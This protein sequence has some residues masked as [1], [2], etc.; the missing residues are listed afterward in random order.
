M[1]RRHPPRVQPPPPEPVVARAERSAAWR[2]GQAAALVWY[3]GGFACLVAGVATQ[4]GPYAWMARWEVR[5]L[6]ANSVMGSFLPGFGVLLLPLLILACLPR[7]DDWPFIAGA[8]S[9][10]WPDE[11]DRRRP[12]PAP[13]LRR[14]MARARDIL[15]WLAAISLLAG[16][17]LCWLSL[18]PGE[19]P[20][21]SPLPSLTLAQATAPGAELPTYARLA[22]ALPR[23]DMAWEHD[24]TIRTTHYH[25]L[26]IP[27]VPSPWHPGDP[28]TVLQLDKGLVAGQPGPP[29]GKLSR[30]LPAWLIAS[31]RD[32]G[33]N[34]AD[35]PVVLTREL[36]NGTAPAP[37]EVDAMLSAVFGGALTIVFGAMA[38]SMHRAGRRLPGGREPAARS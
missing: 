17:V 4:T 6:G 32:A 26:Y 33:L 25:D 29:E 19:Q 18:R 13:A 15:A 34:P 9:A 21:G 3:L 31:M 28:L 36:L 35:D 24:Y 37:D 27:L 5:H 2:W 8:K 12:T 22:D 23:P 7:R 1:T 14:R 20:P 38:F 30:G 16:A 11:R 10:F